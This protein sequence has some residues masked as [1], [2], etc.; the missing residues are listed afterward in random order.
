MF[1]YVLEAFYCSTLI[2]ENRQILHRKDRDIITF[3]SRISVNVDALSTTTHKH[4]VKVYL[5][6]SYFL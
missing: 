6:L 5:F 3:T 1:R 4:E 2:M